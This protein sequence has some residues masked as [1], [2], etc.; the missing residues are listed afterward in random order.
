MS[1]PAKVQYDAQ[2]FIQKTNKLI[3]LNEKSMHQPEQ[4]FISLNLCH[5][6]TQHYITPS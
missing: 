4:D 2:D 3:K 5:V 6:H 1:L